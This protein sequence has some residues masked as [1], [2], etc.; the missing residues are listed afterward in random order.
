MT[1]SPRKLHLATRPG[2]RSDEALSTFDLLNE[3]CRFELVAGKLGQRTIDQYGR[4][5]L[6]FLWKILKPLSEVTE[7]DVLDYLEELHPKAG[8]RAM[9]I[10]GLRSVFGW[11][12]EGELLPRDPMSRIKSKKS[13]AGPAPYLTREEMVR[14]LVAAAWR[15]ILYGRPPKRAW[16]ILLAYATGG[17]AES[18]CNVTR[19]DVRDGYVLFR[20]AKNDYPYDVP[21][22]ALGRAAAEALI[23]IQG[24]RNGTLLGVG[25]T[26]FWQWVREAGQDAGVKAWPHLLR[27]TTAMR[28]ADA[29]VPSTR[30]AEILNHRDLATLQRYVG[31]SDQPKRKAMELID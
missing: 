6:A 17:R 4:A 8:S 23:E 28:L 30:I 2:A 18:L 10:R 29:G 1:D 13:K 5:V 15:D 19:D 21:L 20:V 25:T 31:H 24:D 14:L 11:A 27:H 9:T 12:Y 26:A 7:Q 3:W 16:A 22:N